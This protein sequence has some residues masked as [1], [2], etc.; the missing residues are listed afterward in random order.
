MIRLMLDTNICIYILKQQPVSVLREL[1]KYKMGEIG[2]SMV[3]YGELVYGAYKSSKK[4]ANLSKI[5]ALVDTLEVLAINEAVIHHY[6][7]IRTS[8]EQKGRVIGAH[9]F[10]IAA[11]ALALDVPLITNNTKEFVKVPGLELLNWV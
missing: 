8:L 4:L 2:I 5:E 3:V 9:D 7:E 11:H 6:A 1:K 10:W